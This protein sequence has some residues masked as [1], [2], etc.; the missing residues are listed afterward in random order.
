MPAVKPRGCRAGRKEQKRRRSREYYADSAAG[1]ASN[2]L[3]VTLTNSGRD[4]ATVA[5]HRV[6]EAESSVCRPRSSV[7]RALFKYEE[8]ELF[9][10]VYDT[11]R[12]RIVGQITIYGRPMTGSMSMGVEAMSDSPVNVTY[13]AP[14]EPSRRVSREDIQHARVYVA[15]LDPFTREAGGTMWFNRSTATWDYN[16]ELSFQ[17]GS[18]LYPG[19]QRVMVKFERPVMERQ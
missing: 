14:H 5:A 3:S 19:Q 12:G 7:R 11:S 13:L 4:V 15:L 18:V 9:G 17:P 2:N 16:M 10:A 6:M 8:A 1:D